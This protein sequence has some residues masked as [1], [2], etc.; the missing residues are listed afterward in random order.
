M[1]LTWGEFP[2][3]GLPNGLWLRYGFLFLCLL[4]TTALSNSLDWSRSPFPICPLW[5]H[6]PLLPKKLHVSIMDTVVFISFLL[7]KWNNNEQFGGEEV[8]LSSKFQ[9][10]VHHCGG[11]EDRHPITSP[12]LSWEEWM[13]VPSA[14]LVD[15]P[16]LREHGVFL[17]LWR[18]DLSSFLLINFGMCLYMVSCKDTF[19]Y[20]YISGALVL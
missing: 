9:V 7:L 2:K 16:L 1:K 8:Y 18:L 13:Q 17:F 6:R 20:S 3:P 10:T 19:L 4:A 12:S 15:P 5:K 11:S 14:Q